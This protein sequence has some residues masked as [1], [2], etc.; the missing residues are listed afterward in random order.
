MGYFNMNL[1]NPNF[2][3]LIEDH[4]LSTLIPEPSCFKSINPTSIDNFERSKRSRFM[5]TITFET[6]VS[7]HHKLI[8]MILRT[9][10]AKSKPKKFYFSNL[11][12]L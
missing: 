10:F 4:K 12:R 8:G 11:K 7:D 3:E 1:V 6:S 5:N 9:K 2:C